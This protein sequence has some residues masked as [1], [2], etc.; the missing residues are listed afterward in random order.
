MQ[1]FLIGLES[2]LSL[3]LR[4]FWTMKS[5]LFTPSLLWLNLIILLILAQTVSE[6]NN[7]SVLTIS[8]PQLWVRAEHRAVAV[9][10]FW[11]YSGMTLTF[12]FQDSVLCLHFLLGASNNFVTLV[13]APPR[14]VMCQL[15]KCGFMCVYTRSLIIILLS[16]R[17]PAHLLVWWSPA[18]GRDSSQCACEV[19]STTRY[20]HHW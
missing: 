2:F 16:P 19:W 14:P 4:Y 3:T 13:A 20:H 18:R 1:F 15:A 17:H 10:V 11:S 8:C 5:N 12:R 7:Y 9:A 6:S